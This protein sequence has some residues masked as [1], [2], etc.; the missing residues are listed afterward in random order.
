VRKVLSILTAASLAISGIVVG[1]P[2]QRVASAQ[3]EAAAIEWGPCKP[4]YLKRARARCGFLKVPLDYDRP[5]GRQISLRVSRVRHTSP[6]SQYQGV[7]LGNPG[8]PGPP[9]LF[10]AILGQFVPR[11]AGAT[12]DWIG[13]NPRGTGSSRPSLSCLPNYLAYGLPPYV[14]GKRRIM[15]IWLRRSKRY[16]RACERNHPFLLRHMGTADIVRDMDSIRSALGVR[17]INF[18][19]YSYGTYLGQVYAT[20]FPDRVRRMVLDSNLYPGGLTYKRYV[21]STIALERNMEAWFRWIAKYRKV[22]HLGRT[23]KAVRGRFMA[24]RAKLRRQ[25]AGRKIGPAEW[26]DVFFSAAYARFLWEHLADLFAG[27]VHEDKWKPLKAEYDSVSPPGNDNGL[28]SYL[29]TVCRDVQ[30]PNNWSTWA[31][32]TWRLHKRAPIVAWSTTW[33]FVPCLYWPVPAEEPIEVD[34]GDVDSVLL[35]GETLDGATPFQGS[36]AVR[37]EFPNSSLIA[38]RGGT[39]HGASLNGIACIDNKVATYL[40]TGRRPARKPGRRSDAVCPPFPPPVP[41]G[42]GRALEPSTEQPER[43]LPFPRPIYPFVR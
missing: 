3:A 40:A 7:M 30:F 37:A 18:Y 31:R 28:A 43:P 2:A 42:P 17:R 32:D 8:G 5:N 36:L 16:A 10:M 25:P 35:V 26:V 13:F 24:Q 34:G 22:Y 33:Y 9:G 19:G 15:R 39:T 1:M 29:G 21:D 23:M 4:R 27:W 41:R 6:D 12:Y 11:N 20:L 38:G 14:P